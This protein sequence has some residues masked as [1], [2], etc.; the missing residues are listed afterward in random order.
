MGIFVNIVKDTE[1]KARIIDVDA[2]RKSFKF[3]FGCQIGE[4]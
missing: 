4:R 1:M 2:I 3:W